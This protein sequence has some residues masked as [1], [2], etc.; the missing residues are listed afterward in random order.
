MLV[1]K[2]YVR[3]NSPAFPPIT[4][5][6]LLT[7]FDNSMKIIPCNKYET[8]GWNLVGKNQNGSFGENC[9]WKPPKRV[10]Y[11]IHGILSLLGFQFVKKVWCF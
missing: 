5:P 10:T 4:I 8:V 6:M 11:R 9:I 2:F 1:E 7:N 3:G